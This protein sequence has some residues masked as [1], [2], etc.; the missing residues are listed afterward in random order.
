MYWKEANEHAEFVEDHFLFSSWRMQLDMDGIKCKIGRWNM[1][2]IRGHFSRFT[3]YFS[4]K[5]KIF[6]VLGKPQTRL[7]QRTV[8]LYRTGFVGYA[9]ARIIHSFYDFLLQLKI[10][11]L[12]ISTNG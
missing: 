7:T 9:A 12:H 3:S 2:V 4:Q 11:L 5:D 8:G 10:K 1:P 6:L